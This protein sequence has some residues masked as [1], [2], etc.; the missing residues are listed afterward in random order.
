MFFITIG[1]LMVSFFLATYAR[2]KYQGHQKILKYI[3]I[4]NI[5]LLIIVFYITLFVF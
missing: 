2:K 4:A 5:I 1:L 3:S